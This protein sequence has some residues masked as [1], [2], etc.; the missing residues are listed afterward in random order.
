MNGGNNLRNIIYF[1][2]F[3]SDIGDPDVLPDYKAYF[4]DDLNIYKIETVISDFDL[5]KEDGETELRINILKTFF[6]KT[7]EETIKK[8]NQYIKK[9]RLKLLFHFQAEWDNWY[10]LNNYSY[11]TVWEDKK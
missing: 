9:N 5:W 1:E 4:D 8:I 11:V 3:S 2:F 10:L 6:E 7:E